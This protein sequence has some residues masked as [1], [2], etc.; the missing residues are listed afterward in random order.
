MHYRKA[1]SKQTRRFDRLSFLGVVLFLFAA[2]LVARLFVLQVLRHGFYAA[3]AEERAT[4]AQRLTP[5]R[6]QVYFRDGA[7]PSDLLPLAVNRTMRLVY[8]NPKQIKDPETVLQRL[9]KIVPFDHDATLAKLQ[10][11]NDQYEP[12]LHNVPKEIADKIDLLNLTGIA[13]TPETSRFYPFA[14]IASQVTGFVGYQGAA[15]Q[16]Q[17]GIEGYWDGQLSGAA[18]RLGGKDG[19]D[20]SSATLTEARNGDSLILTIDRTVQHAVCYKLSE[21]V[22]KHGADGGSVIVMK[23]D[24]GA[25]IALCNA[26]SFDANHYADTENISVYS[27][28]AITDQFEPGSVMK[29][30]TLSAALDQGLITPDSTYTDE[31]SVK[32]GKYTIRNSE[33]KTYGV[34]TMSGV[35]EQSINTGA[36]FVAQKLGIEKFR[37]YVGRFGFGEQ[38]GIELQGEGAGNISALEKKGD[39][40]LAT[41]SFG[42]GIAATPLQLLMAYAAIANDGKLMKPYIVEERLGPNGYREKTEPTIVRQVIS[43]AAARMMQSMLVNVVRK[44]HG[45][46]AAVPGFYVAGKTGTAQVPLKD[47]AGY[48]PNRHIGTFVGMAPITKPE[49]VMVVKIIDP[50]DVQFAES[51]AAPL[52]GD[53]AS[54]LLKYYR[55]TPDDQEATK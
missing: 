43:P 25:I 37:D 34:Q 38:T 2:G 12:L 8:A 7:N 32:I 31:G 40:Y 33:N 3:L 36:I 29:T 35:L 16:G 54:F 45:K 14:D 42:Q 10:R 27:N 5:T 51:S 55:I 28:S 21:A 26:P 9:E 13:T 1:A 44:G 53:V 50:K 52:F 11:S 39:I 49:F 47:R 17:Y 18:G 48:D 19:N 20:A 4:L 41:A 24:T 23:P 30:M 6:G 22:Q 15:R 46:R